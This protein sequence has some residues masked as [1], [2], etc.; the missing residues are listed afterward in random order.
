MTG[1]GYALG[2]FQEI[3]IRQA[4][5]GVSPPV[6]SLFAKGMAA[7]VCMHPDTSP[8][9]ISDISFIEGNVLYGCGQI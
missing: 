9:V 1:Y 4:A 2:Y 5:W 6:L 8:A 3:N 7:H